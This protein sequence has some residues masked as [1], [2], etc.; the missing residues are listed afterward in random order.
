MHAF[1]LI[2]PVLVLM[3]SGPDLPAQK[4]IPSPEETFGFRMGADKKLIDWTQI[5]GYFRTV[6]A[7]S[8]RVVVEEL[9]VGR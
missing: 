8:D 3:V 1:R 9:G 4:S 6:D 2:L 5:A 7:A